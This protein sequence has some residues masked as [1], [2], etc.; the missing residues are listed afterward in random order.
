MVGKALAEICTRGYI[1]TSAGTK[2][3]AL[4]GSQGG[5]SL[6]QKA[7]LDLADQQCDQFILGQTLTGGTD[8][9]GSRAL[10][11]I[12]KGTLDGVVDGVADF[13]GE[14]LIH[15]FMPAIVAVNWGE[16][17]DIPEMWAKRKEHKDE[18]ALAERDVSLG[19]LE[20][21]KAWPPVAKNV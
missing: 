20:L 7:L 6:P 5:D 18:K 19:N 8:D 13:V 4:D 1:M 9:T 15:Q 12:H 17:D 16:R 2:I 10:G 21:N 11:E 3:N 14:I